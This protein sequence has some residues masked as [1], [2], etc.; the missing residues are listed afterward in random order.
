MGFPIVTTSGTTPCERER[1][2]RRA[3][4][5]EAGLHLVRNDHS[6]SCP[7]G[8]VGRGQ[9][10]GVGH[11][12]AATSRQRFGDHPGEGF[13][14]VGQGGVGRRPVVPGRRR[15]AERIDAIRIRSGQHRDPWWSS[16]SARSA[17]L[18]RAD[19]DQRR[20]VAVVAVVEANNVERAGGGPNQPDGQLVGLTS[21][22]D[23]EHHLERVGQGVASRSA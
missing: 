15:A 4:P 20:R 3:D 8:V 23:E 13:G 5:P 22:I 18:V 2:E 16:R 9:H 7:N 10:A 6:A 19:V 12:L 17:E 1:P 14:S 21:R 11:D